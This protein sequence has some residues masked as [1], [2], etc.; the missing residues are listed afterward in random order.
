MLAINP[1][2]NFYPCIRYMESSLGENQ[3]PYIIGDIYNGIGQEEK[4]KKRVEILNAITK[5]SQSS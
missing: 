4:H 3:E 1:D 5:T 2:G